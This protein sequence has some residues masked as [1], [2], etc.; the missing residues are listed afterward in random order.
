[1]GGGL[2]LQCALRTPRRLGALF[3]ISSYLNEGAAGYA[4]RAASPRAWPPIWIRHG[5]ADDF[6]LPSWGEATARR[7]REMGANVEWATEA[8]V[9]HTMSEAELRQLWGWLDEQLFALD[10]AD[11]ECATEA[12]R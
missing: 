6:I 7:F 1:M 2:A 4:V 11:C 9:A 12:D 8:G 5:A 3:A 10:H